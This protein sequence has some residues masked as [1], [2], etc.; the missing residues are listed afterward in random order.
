MECW[1]LR[2][3]DTLCSTNSQFQWPKVV[4]SGLAL[5]EPSA[6][7]YWN[8]SPRYDIGGCCKEFQSS[9]MKALVKSTLVFDFV[10]KPLTS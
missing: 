7:L 1:R 8:L 2:G 6:C 9:S 5:F 4:E 10:G 3:E